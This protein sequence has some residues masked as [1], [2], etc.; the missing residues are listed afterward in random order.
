[1]R[2][3][4]WWTAAAVSLAMAAC[5]QGRDVASANVGSPDEH[6][7]PDAVCVGCSAGADGVVTFGGVPMRFTFQAGTGF[8]LNPDQTTY[9][10]TPG[11]GG[12]GAA[13]AGTLHLDPVAGGPGLDG[14]IDTAVS[15]GRTNDI[16]SGTFS[17]TVGGQR[18]TMQVTDGYIVGLGPNT[19]VQFTAP[20]SMGPAVV[21][22]GFLHVSSL[23]SCHPL[24]GD[25][26]CWCLDNKQCE[27]C[28]DANAGAA[29]PTCLEGTCWN[30]ATAV[31]EACASLPP[32]PTTLAQ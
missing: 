5:G 24:C 12:I 6:Q 21:E 9:S 16:L 13:S 20:T 29:T 17:G 1:M 23:F 18:F 26:Q 8:T 4:G 30:P 27:P 2:G 28:A 7:G 31:C 22:S 10:F 15:C 11:V 19:T 32:P 25:G 14:T 3:S